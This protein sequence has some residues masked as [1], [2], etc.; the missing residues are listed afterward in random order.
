[1]I[2]FL[3]QCVLYEAIRITTY[4]GLE[5]SSILCKVMRDIEFVRFRRYSVLSLIQ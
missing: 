1:M 2:L 4:R 3:F 5:I